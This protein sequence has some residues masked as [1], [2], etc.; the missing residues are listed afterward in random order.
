V[1]LV[2][3]CEQ[4]SFLGYCP[5]SQDQP[6][7]GKNYAISQISGFLIG[8]FSW[9]WMSKKKQVSSGPSLRWDLQTIASLKFLPDRLTSVVF[10]NK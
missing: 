8:I 3:Q 10:E 2:F 9:T 1:E 5:K 6:C 4:P 7:Q